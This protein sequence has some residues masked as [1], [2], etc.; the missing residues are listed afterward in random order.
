MKLMKKEVQSVHIS[1]LLRSGNKIPMGRDTETVWNR[2][3]KKGHPET[4]P[5]RDQR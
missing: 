4:A 1:L 3:F 2:D 5:T